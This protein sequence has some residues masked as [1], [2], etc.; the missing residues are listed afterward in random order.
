[1]KSLLGIMLAVTGN[2]SGQAG[3]S[4]AAAAAEA[5]LWGSAAAAVVDRL[6]D[7]ATKTGNEDAQQA[8]GS[9]SSASSIAGYMLQ[10]L[11]LCQDAELHLCQTNSSGWPEPAHLRT[12]LRFG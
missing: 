1:V 3:S 5:L 11:K 8:S 9:D 6:V 2:S 7:E 12:L 10:Q 4:A